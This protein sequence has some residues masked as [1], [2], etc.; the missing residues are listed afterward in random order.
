MMPGLIRADLAKLFRTKS[1]YVCL[2]IAVILGASMAYLY[3][4][5]CVSN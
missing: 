2:G 5:F 1:L 3:H 4:L